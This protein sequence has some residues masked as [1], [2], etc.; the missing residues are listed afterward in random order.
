MDA[1]Q[2]REARALFRQ[3]QFNYAASAAVSFLYGV[4]V[5]ALGGGWWLVAAVVPVALAFMGWMLVGSLGDLYAAEGDYREA[6]GRVDGFDDATAI[7][8][9]RTA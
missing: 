6:K 3:T 9:R 1:D 8:Q 5:M 7:F 4:T 2:R